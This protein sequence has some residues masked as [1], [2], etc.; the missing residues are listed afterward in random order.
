MFGGRAWLLL[1][2]N[3]LH[4]VDL[5]TGSNPRTRELG[6][7]PA[8][9]SEC[10]GGR[11]WVLGP[12]GVLRGHSLR[13]GS[14]PLVAPLSAGTWSEVRAAGRWVIVAGETELVLVDAET[15]EVER[16]VELPARRKAP[17]SVTARQMAVAVD[18]PRGGTLLL[19][20][21]D[22]AGLGR[23]GSVRL[24]AAAN[25]VSLEG[26]SVYVSDAEGALS[27]FRPRNEGQRGARHLWTRRLGGP[28]S[29]APVVHSGRL[30]VFSLDNWL[31]ILNPEDGALLARVRMERR[32]LAPPVVLSRDTLVVQPWGSPYLRELHPESGRDGRT[33]WSGAEWQ[34][35][36]GG[37]SSDDRQEWFVAT[38]GP[39]EWTIAGFQNV[40]IVLGS[41]PE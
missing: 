5:A 6:G 19:F 29:T 8:S 16:L 25:L 39:W 32:I 23:P 15:A 14:A 26:E 27:A 33:W 34:K 24:P 18:A 36:V 28:L 9:A 30:F 11:I 35:V 37:P 10:S 4:S 41:G 2:G 21:L 31:R 20:R 1:E 40:P 7:E 22:D 12:D 3:Q 13:P 38:L 17:V